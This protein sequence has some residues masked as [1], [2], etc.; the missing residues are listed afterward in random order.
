MR[1]ILASLA[2]WAGFVY[3]TL[4]PSVAVASAATHEH[5][6]PSKAPSQNPIAPKV[7][8]ISMFVDEGEAWF[9]VPKFNILGQNITV[10]GLSPLFPQV[11]CTADGDICL[12]TTGEGEINA[13]VSITSL[14][15][16]P[17]FDL[18]KTYFL[19]AGVAGIS[20]K[21]GTI[22]SAAFARYAV[23]VGLQFE[24]DAR[25]IPSNFTTGYVPQGARAPNQFPTE[26]YGTEVFELNDE[27]RQFAIKQAKTAKLFDDAGSQAYRAN[28]ASSHAFAAGAAPPSIVACD[29]ATSDQF[30]SG[31]LLA[32]A[33][34]NTTQLFTNGTGVYCTSQQEDNATLEALM[35]AALQN[36]V[37]FTRIVH[38]RTASDFDREFP[39]QT[40]SDN[41]FFGLSGFTASINNLVNAGLPVVT[42][43]V[44]GWQKTFE[45]GIKPKNYVGDIFG[46]LGGQPDFGPGS[47]FNGTKALTRRRLSRRFVDLKVQ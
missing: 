7:F 21:L 9:S 1:S 37:D 36:L 40:A 33:F 8:I 44:D 4:I 16:S 41:L 26:I 2:C 24:I 5:G 43:I 32:S 17:H 47:L 3:C 38:M 22:G 34:E 14:T 18:T 29:T 28:Y 35:R 12:I 15:H 13:A 10:P 46:S 39:G 20:P 31:T 30:W 19:I 45:K 11:H 27:L 42:G 23:Q 25:Q 6:G